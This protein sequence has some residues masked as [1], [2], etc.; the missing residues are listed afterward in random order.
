MTPEDLAFE[1][2]P[3]VPAGASLR[4]DGGTVTATSPYVLVRRT[5]GSGSERVLVA[6]HVTVAVGDRVALLRFGSEWLVIGKVP[7]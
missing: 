6:A 5:S 3:D 1:L 4:G 7:L 2:A